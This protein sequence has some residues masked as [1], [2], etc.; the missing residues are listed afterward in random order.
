ML[1]LRG[2]PLYSL[3]IAIVV[4]AAAAL[5]CQCR[6]AAVRV[7]PNDVADRKAEWQLRLASCLIGYSLQLVHLLPLVCCG[8][9][10]QAKVPPLICACR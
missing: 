8:S 7:I 2:L 5:L 10:L 4:E 1:I 6:S 9:W 3:R